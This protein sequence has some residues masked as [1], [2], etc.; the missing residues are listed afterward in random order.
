MP[1]EDPLDFSSDLPPED[2]T[3]ANPLLAQN[4]GRWA[5]AYYRN[6]PERRAEAVRDLLRELRAAAPGATVP[7]SVAAMGPEA[8]DRPETLPGTVCGHCQYVNEEGA[9]FCGSCGED[10]LL[11]KILATHGAAAVEVSG[12]QKDTRPKL[13]RA[14]TK[15][16]DTPRFSNARATATRGSAA[17]KYAGAAI[18]IAIIAAGLASWWWTSGHTWPAKPRLPLTASPATPPVQAPLPE[19]TSPIPEPGNPKSRAKKAAREAKVTR[20][21]ETVGEATSDSGGN[22]QASDSK[23]P[24]TAPGA[25]TASQNT[26]QQNDAKPGTRD[27]LRAQNLLAGKDSARD[28]EEAAKLLWKAVAKG[29]TSAAMLLAKLYLAGD[30]VPRSCDEARLLLWS[31]SKTS[32]AA[33][34]ELREL[35]EKGCE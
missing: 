35:E 9:R 26:G 34:D 3:P 14:P 16:A 6:P 1:P 32:S 17:R 21:A 8:H 11:P 33:G 20:T 25:E 18:V 4:M 23:P 7:A 13:R 22:T 24:A 10:L 28:P 27:F 2:L 29:N 15:A 5:E 12:G 19:A 30:G 31:A